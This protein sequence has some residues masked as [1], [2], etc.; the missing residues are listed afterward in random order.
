[1]IVAAYIIL[2]FAYIGAEL[3]NPFGND[4]ND[5]PLDSFC[6]KLAA[7]INM[8]AASTPK[9]S[10]TFI[11][12]PANRLLHPLSDEGYTVWSERSIEEL[13]EGLRKRA[14]RSMEVGSR[15]VSSKG[16]KGKRDR[17]TREEV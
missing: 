5:L 7:E 14:V 11:R 16:G 9:T 10:T 4:V 12:D 3:E 1:M 17:S 6:D 8:I 15:R 13:R 2:G